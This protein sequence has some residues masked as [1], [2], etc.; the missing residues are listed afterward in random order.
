MRRP[1]CPKCGDRKAMGVNGERVSR[2]TYWLPRPVR[3]LLGGIAYAVGA[4]LVGYALIGLFLINLLDGEGASIDTVTFAVVIFCL[5]SGFIAVGVIL[6]RRRVSQDQIVCAT[7]GFTWVFRARAMPGAAGTAPFTGT[8]DE[9]V[10][11]GVDRGAFAGRY[12][13]G[14]GPVETVHEVVAFLMSPNQTPSEGTQS[15]GESDHSYLLEQRKI[16]AVN[17]L[18]EI[19][20]SAGVDALIEVLSVDTGYVAP[21]PKDLQTKTARRAVLEQL[22]RRKAPAAVDAIIATLRGEAHV[23]RTNVRL[24]RDTARL[25]QAY[26][27]IEAAVAA[28]ASIG[29]RRAVPALTEIAEDD[30]YRKS[31]RKAARGALSSISGS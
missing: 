1:R 23:W 16:Q 18:S 13:F 25:V 28:L 20:G 27:H 30:T 24:Q 11:S 29:D 4:S 22:G 15:S 5:G 8:A 26:A 3:W 14:Q 12:D 9:Q 17:A 19:E 6:F 7:C 10:R 31:I 21:F 2:F